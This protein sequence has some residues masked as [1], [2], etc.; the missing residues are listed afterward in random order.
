MK[1]FPENPQ[2][3]FPFFL[4]IVLIGFVSHNSRSVPEHLACRIQI[5]KGALSRFEV[6][7]TAPLNSTIH[8]NSKFR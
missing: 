6:K 2:L 7:L 3:L 8:F 5:K 4:T 1:S